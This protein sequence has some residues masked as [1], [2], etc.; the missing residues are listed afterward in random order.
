MPDDTKYRAF[1]SYSHADTRWAK[2]L[3]YELERFKIDRDLR[4][5]ETSAGAIPNS[6]RPIFRDRDEFT[7]GHTLKQ[8]TL[9]ALNQSAAMIV[10]CSPHSAKS[11]YV[12][13]EVRLFKW[14]HPERPV[15]PV[16]VDGQPGNPERE[17]FGAALKFRITEEGTVTEEPLEILAADVRDSA[18][19]KELGL[20]KVIARLLGLS[21]DEVFRRA[22]RHR[23][24]QLRI[25]NATIAALG[26]LL[27]A[28]VGFAAQ[29]YLLMKTTES[30]LGKSLNYSTRLMNR[31]VSQSVEYGVDTKKTKE[32]L[33]TADGLVE[34]LKPLGS[35][36]PMYRHRKA[37]MH[38][39]LARSYEKLGSLDARQDHIEDA[40]RLMVGLTRDYPDCDFYEREQSITHIERGKIFEH[41]GN[42]TDALASYEQ[43]RTIR[44]RL[45]E[46]AQSGAPEQTA[47]TCSVPEPMGLKSK[48]WRQELLRGKAIIESRIGLILQKEGKTKEALKA[49]EKSL[50]IRKGLFD[51]DP[52]DED[53]QRDLAVGYEY[54][55]NANLELKQFD[56]AHAN[57]ARSV[58]RRRKL[59]QANPKNTR[60]KRDQW[61]GIAKIGSLY[62]Q[63][64]DYTAAVASWGEALKTIK[65]LS[66][67]DPN[68]K[69]WRLDLAKTYQGLGDAERSQNNVQSAAAHYRTSLEIK[70]ELS[71]SDPLNAEWQKS[72]ALA[73]ERLGALEKK[74]GN[75]EPAEN[76]Y[77][78]A[79]K[80][81]EAL[82]AKYPN[83]NDLKKR[84]SI[85]HLGL[86][87]VLEGAQRVQHLEKAVQ[88]INEFKSRGGELSRKEQFE[89]TR[90]KSQLR[91]SQR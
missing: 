2:W 32:L 85:P 11:R 58:R 68:N 64:R 45:I 89:F 66:E 18:D 1:L 70:R 51:T 3:H 40:H 20:A 38:I 8:Q 44:D 27:V 42:L 35:G 17:C 31:I 83:N 19:G 43:S 60:Y 29:Y 16:I 34:S 49:H 22:E 37:R 24:R 88:V 81:Y 7:A 25:R 54:V 71:G 23:R 53:W 56:E 91:Q 57:L 4:A 75:K 41:E 21:T 15:I 62:Y 80:I 69:I 10:I 5:R 72:L 84:S 6:L 39:E 74:R 73:Y 61:V 26:V 87:D 67:S 28:A 52:M 46:R 12:N 90:R 79:Q 9:L 47:K 33:N 59:S 14:R 76:A 48:T 82:V 30:A 78:N 63:I 65:P 77:R 50:K 13:E 55:A 86:A 36:S